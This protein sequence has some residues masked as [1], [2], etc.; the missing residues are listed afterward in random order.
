MKEKKEQK[1]SDLKGDF[2]LSISPSKDATKK[3]G[4]K[5]TSND[6][7]G[8]DFPITKKAAWLNMLFCLLA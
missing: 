6:L 3:K 1:K 5:Q 8:I 7:R 2:S 4:T